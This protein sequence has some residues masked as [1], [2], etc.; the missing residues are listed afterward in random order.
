MN[1]R[2][3][4]QRFWLRVLLFGGLIWGVHELISVVFLSQG[5]EDST[6]DIW[7]VA[8][9]GVTILAATALAFWHRRIACIWLTANSV[10][11]GT[12]LSSYAFRTHEFRLADIVAALLPVLYAIALDVIE[13]RRWPGALE[14]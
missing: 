1:E 9:N 4:L 3:R 12:A 2:A 5:S 8:E 14:K 11:V 6:F 13:I 7:A 10:I